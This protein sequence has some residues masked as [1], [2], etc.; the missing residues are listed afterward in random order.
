MTTATTRPP[1]P[2]VATGRWVVDP[3]RSTATFSVANFGFR[4]VHGTVPVLSGTLE[5]SDGRPV[6]V[7]AELD[8][9]RID[10]GNRRRDADLRKPNLLDLDAS[11]LL[12]YEAGEFDLGPQGWCARGSLGARGTTCPLPVLGVVAGTEGSLHLVGTAVVDRTALGVRAPAL[13]I[14][15]QVSVVVDARLDRA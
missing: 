11:P 10:T 14:G 6:R 9:A 5:V 7:S 13:I 12:T 8:L 4:T 2:V 1:A 15:R 3:A